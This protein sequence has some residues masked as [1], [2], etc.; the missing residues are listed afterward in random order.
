VYEFEESKFSIVRPSLQVAMRGSN[1]HSVVE[2]ADQFAIFVN[3]ICFY[4][5]PKR[6]FPAE[7]IE[8]FRGLLHR[9][10]AAHGKTFEVSRR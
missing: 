7:Q 8:P 3:K 10:L 2:L 1:I 9:A 6:F 5:V 4:A